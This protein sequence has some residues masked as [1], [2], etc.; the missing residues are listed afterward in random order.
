MCT[1]VILTQSGIGIDPPGS[2]HAILAQDGPMLHQGGPEDGL[3]NDMGA[4]QGNIGQSRKHIGAILS[5]DEAILG[6]KIKNIGLRYVCASSKTENIV[7]PSVFD[8]F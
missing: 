3:R 2:Y 7:F 4:F 6:P 8:R 1:Y 5:Q